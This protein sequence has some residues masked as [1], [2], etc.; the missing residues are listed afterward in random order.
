MFSQLFMNSLSFVLRFVSLAQN[1]YEYSSHPQNNLIIV[2]QNILCRYNFLK[3]YFCRHFI[4]LLDSRS[5]YWLFVKST[6][7]IKLYFKIIKWEDCK[8][9]SLLLYR[10]FLFLNKI[11]NCLWK[12]SLQYLKNKVMSYE[13]YFCAERK[14]HFC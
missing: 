3:S 12:I 13:Q 2:S 10:I 14:K 5:S 7:K 4:S 9:K 8:N 11:S 1:I 6:N